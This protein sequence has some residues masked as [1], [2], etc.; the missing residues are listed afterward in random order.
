NNN[1]PWCPD[2]SVKELLDMVKKHANM[3]LLIPLPKNTFLDSREIHR[4]CGISI[5]LFTKSYKTMGLFVDELVQRKR[6]E[7]VCSIFLLNCHAI[8]IHNYD[9]RKSLAC[10]QIQL[11]IL[12]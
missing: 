5:L 7:T 10:A 11:Q 4:H 1:S 3:H 8:G 6:L 9:Y 2:E 12:L